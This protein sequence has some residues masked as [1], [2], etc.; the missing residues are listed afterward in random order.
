MRSNVKTL[1]ACLFILSMALFLASCGGSS[2]GDSSSPP[3][4]NVSG[5]W[6]VTETITSPGTCGAGGPAADIYTLEVIHDGVSNT[7]TIRDTRAAPS[8]T[9][10][11]SGDMV[12]FDNERY[13][14][15]PIECDTMWEKATVTLNASLTSFSGTGTITCSWI[16]PTPG[17]CYV[18]TSLV[19]NKQ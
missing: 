18:N 10:R 2:G 14:I 11:I 17:S 7:I 6:D 15:I 19:G 3:A 5:L 4:G 1:M 8:T 16:D 13:N 9:A 12:I